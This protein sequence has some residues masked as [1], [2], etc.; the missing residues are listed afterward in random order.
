MCWDHLALPSPPVSGLHTL[1]MQCWMRWQGTW[2]DCDA[3][4]L[5]ASLV[6][7]CPLRAWASPEGDRRAGTG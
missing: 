3:L 4:I 5:P 6:L 1:R 7:H 2:A